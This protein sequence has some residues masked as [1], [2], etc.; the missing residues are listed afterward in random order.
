[1]AS[2]FDSTY[3]F[4]YRN[5]RRHTM[6]M[7]KK[8]LIS[9]ASVLAA[10]AF[11]VPAAAQAAPHVYRNGVI[12]AEGKKVRLIGWGTLSFSNET[13]GSVQCHNIMG[14]YAENPIGGGAIVGEVQAFNAY[15]CPSA[16]CESL[17][18]TRLEVTPE[19]LPWHGEVSEPQ[20]GVFTSPFGERGKGAGSIY[21]RATC[22]SPTKTIVNA[23]FYGETAPRIQNDG[24][25]I[26]AGPGEEEFNESSG[27]L[28]SE[29]VGIGR[30]EGKFKV[31]GYAA[32]ELLE[33]KNP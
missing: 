27:G 5:R 31:E 11:L 24:I 8:L 3:E 18:G 16:S 1:M 28:E 26:G 30:P 25:A 9:L 20:A 13:L 14:G 12:A 32:E 23:Q 22:E 6:K 15:E 2:S 17:G 21:F 19:K 29:S 7:N 10:A 4:R 33:V